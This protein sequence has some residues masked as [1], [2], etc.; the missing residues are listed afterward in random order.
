MESLERC[1]GFHKDVDI[2][3]HKVCSPNNNN[4]NNNNN[5]T[6]NITHNTESTAM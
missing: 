4:N 5:N 2:C 6:W 3:T 1:D